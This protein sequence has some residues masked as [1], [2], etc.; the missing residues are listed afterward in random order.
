MGNDGK[1]EMG[2]M[3]KWGTVTYMTRRW[4]DGLDTH[5]VNAADQPTTLD[6]PNASG[7]RTFI[8][9]PFTVR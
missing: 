8:N 4:H 5:A 3:G 9:D 2:E 1:W 6:R 7:A